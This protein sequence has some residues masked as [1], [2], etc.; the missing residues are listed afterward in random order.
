MG[1]NASTSPRALTR[2][3]RTLL[4]SAAVALAGALVSGAALAGCSE[5][6]KANG[7]STSS[8][9][10]GNELQVA[11][12]GAIQPTAGDGKTVLSR[13]QGADWFHGKVPAPKAADTSKEPIKVGFMNVDSAPIGAMPELH[14]ATDATQKFIN[15]ELGG[16][17]G[18]PVEIVPCLLSNGLAPEEAAGCARKLVDA[19]VVA[20][21]GGIGLSNGAA[22][23]IFQE[24][25]IP[26]VGGIPVNDDEMTSPVSFQ[27][28]GGSPGAFVGFAEQAVA[29][30]G[31]KK[32]AVLY[33]D[34]PSIKSAAVDYG[35]AVA[36]ARGAEVTEV[37]FPMV[38]Q[39][40]TAAVQKA[41]EGNP[42][43]IF[44]AAADLSCAP[45]MQAIV[46]LQTKATVYMVGSCADIKQLDKVGTDKLAGFHFNI[47]N[48]I[49][50]T[51]DKLADTE[52]YNLAMQKY[53]PDTTPRGA[54]TVAFKGGM[55]LWAVLDQLGPDATSAQIIDAFRKAK[56]APSFDG[57]PYTCDGK[58]V[59]GKQAM[60]APQQIIAV[61]KAGNQFVEASDGW[62]DVPKV[63]NETINKK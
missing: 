45:I 7:S 63:L 43:A 58:Q 57:H 42:D 15:D 31:A 14:T 21:L 22:L 6:D 23:Q 27:F 33:A 49:D 34:Y 50:Q 16:I 17:D 46:D 8:K 18:R 56:D 20:V 52:I 29:K 39:D 4:A 47:E 40:Y 5:S 37:S 53:A 28:S 48:R 38:S 62:I 26:F 41:V 12:D 35:A 61:L 60:C 19:K 51:A 1:K 3:G 13:F 30:E 11:P 25:G 10:S 44:V 36:K 2:P 9:T 24:N 54:A 32:V 55:N 59:P